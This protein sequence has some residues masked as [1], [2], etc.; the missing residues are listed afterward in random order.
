MNT[1]IALSALVV[2]TGVTGYFFTDR[3]E[4]PQD[5][6]AD[7]DHLKSELSGGYANLDWVAKH[8]NLDL[9]ALAQSTEDQLRETTSARKAKRIIH[10]F[11]ASFKDPHLKAESAEPRTEDASSN[12][13]W[14]GPKAS[15][16]TK[17][18]LD[19]FGYRKSS[20]DWGIDFEKVEGFV[21]LSEN[22]NPFP[23]GMVAL[24]DGRK[25]GLIRIKYFG[26]DRYY[27][28]AEEV[29]PV[30]QKELQ[31]ESCNSDC[32]W[33]FRLQ[34][35]DQL[36]DRFKTNLTHLE[37]AGIDGLVIDVTAN[38]GGTEWA[39]DV[40]R[41]FTTQPI[42]SPAFSL[43]KHP[44]W[45]K[46]IDEEVNSLRSDLEQTG[47]SSEIKEQ[48][49]QALLDH[50]TLL[51]SIQLGCDSSALWETNAA[52]TC[53]RLAQDK[54]GR[55]TPSSFSE[56]EIRALESE[57][58]LFSS[59]RHTEYVGLYQGPLFVAMDGGSASATEQFATLLQYNQAAT[60]VG[61]ASYGA[62]CGYT[63][64]GIYVYLEHTGLRVWMS[65]CA[66]TR[67]D[68]EN[69][70]AGVNPDLPG[71]QAGAKGKTRAKALVETLQAQ[72]DW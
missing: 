25:L 15:A 5:W 61:E 66:R 37:S 35:R 67:A 47:L 12:Y 53:S 3:H 59:V 30:F 11:L 64:G 42:M 54:H 10:T 9:V 62:G 72:S 48:L 56:N 44:H 58:I 29:W 23:T 1:K 21:D 4:D 45:E 34:V 68:G 13:V 26:E 7:F 6:L 2:L 17:Q 19:A 55:L 51:Q 52:L 33:R 60:V 50:E 39:E 32:A 57:D 46:R 49:D 18:A 14:T 27:R 63:N 71:W 38:G 8:H 20:Y 22:N 24:N 16:T 41:L 43:V 28:V 36:M 31:D 69:E 65:D 40:A 70:L